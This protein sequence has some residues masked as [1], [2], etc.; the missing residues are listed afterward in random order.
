[1]LVSFHSFQ[2]YSAHSGLPAILIVQ[3]SNFMFLVFPGVRPFL[4]W[5]PAPNILI[6]TSL[7]L[8]HWPWADLNSKVSAEELWVRGVGGREGSGQ[9]ELSW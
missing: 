1:M 2:V 9:W 4:L 6:D 8:S 7:S 5:F 3:K